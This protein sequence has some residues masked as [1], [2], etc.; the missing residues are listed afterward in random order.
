[1]TYTLTTASGRTATVLSDDLA[2]SERIAGL[3]PEG[4]IVVDDFDARN[5][6]KQGITYTDW[7]GEK[8][9]DPPFMFGLTLCCQASDKGMEDGVFCRACY[10]TKPDAD[11][12]S[13]L[14]RADDGSFPDLDPIK[15]LD[16]D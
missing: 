7:N 13:Y 5:P 16:H 14:Y 3:D 11:A 9:T 1:M 6:A 4:R 12:G 2:R 8:R 10:G 15:G